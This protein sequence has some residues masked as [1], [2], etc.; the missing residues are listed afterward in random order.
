[1]SQDDDGAMN[2]SPR[3]DEAST[4]W[5]AHLWSEYAYRHD[6]IWKR[7]FRTVLVVAFLS[8][9]PYVHDDLIPTFRWAILLV[10]L[11][12]LPFT[13]GAYKVIANEYTLFTIV[14]A[15]TPR[16][17]DGTF[18]GCPAPTNCWRSTSDVWLSVS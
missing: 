17:D 16:G 14:P 9:V 12:A 2:E 13:I 11:L 10:P 1:M 6:L 3:P 18:L 15:D 4:A 7:I 8:I 5:L